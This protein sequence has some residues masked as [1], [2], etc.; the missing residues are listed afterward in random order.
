MFLIKNGVAE[1][2]AW[3]LSNAE[4]LARCVTFGQFE[5]GEYDWHRREWKEKK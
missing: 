2:T 5:G 1:E 3:G 4:R